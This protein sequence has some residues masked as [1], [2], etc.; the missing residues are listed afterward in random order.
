M[1]E[2]DTHAIALVAIGVGILVVF[3]LGRWFFGMARADGRR[4]TK[5]EMVQHDIDRRAAGSDEEQYRAVGK[6][7]R[8]CGCLGF[9][10]LIVIGLLIFDAFVLQGE[11]FQRI[12]EA[13]GR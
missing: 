7:V 2:I 3:A 13:L 12:M 9:I 4:M 1:P 6:S 5:R 10:A 11:V 8:G